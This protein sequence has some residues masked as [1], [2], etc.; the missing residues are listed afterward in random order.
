MDRKSFSFEI[1]KNIVI[2]WG[3][4]QIDIKPFISMEEQAV[5]IENYV[6]NYFTA[7]GDLTLSQSRVLAEYMSKLDIIEMCTN[8]VREEVK[9]VVFYNGLWDEIEKNIVNYSEYRRILDRILEQASRDVSD[10]KQLG[11]IVDMFAI[12][13]ESMLTKLGS[14][15]ESFKPEDLD[16]AKELAKT[17]GDQLKSPVMAGVLEDMKRGATT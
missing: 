14:S 10:R 7:M 4:N 3:K 9:D 1:P 11:S 16:K 17:L 15:L 6:V 13:I 5:V 2:N 12:K 8:M